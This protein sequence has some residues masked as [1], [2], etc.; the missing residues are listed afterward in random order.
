MGAIQSPWALDQALY[1]TWLCISEATLLAPPSI[2]FLSIRIFGLR[3]QRNFDAKQIN[4][5]PHGTVCIP[6][7]PKWSCI[8]GVTITLDSWYGRGRIFWELL[9][10]ITARAR[11]W[12][13][14]LTRGKRLFEA[15]TKS[16]LNYV[17]MTFAIFIIISQ[18]YWQMIA[19]IRTFCL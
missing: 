14:V 17:S 4:V 10:T 6:L 12:L 5:Y 18:V 9:T 2:S 13:L 3:E 16:F 11:L 15:H 1:L 7:T 8:V 19:L